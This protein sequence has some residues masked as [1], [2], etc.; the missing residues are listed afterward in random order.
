[1]RFAVGQP[2]LAVPA[3][4][5]SPGKNSPAPLIINGAGINELVWDWCAQ[6]PIAAEAPAPRRRLYASAAHRTSPLNKSRPS[7]FL[8]I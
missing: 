5:N 7:L 8:Y 1:M 4:M 2:A 6:L 3:A